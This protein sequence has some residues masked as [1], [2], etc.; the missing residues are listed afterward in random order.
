MSKVSVIVP[1]YGVEPYLR[2]CLDSLVNQTLKDI[3]IIMCID[4]VSPDNCELICNEYADKYENFSLIKPPKSGLSGTRNAG[5]EVAK[6]DFI[7]YVDS[8]DWVETDTLE[9]MYDLAIKNDCEVVSV[10]SISAYGDIDKIENDKEKLVVV[11]GKKVFQSW[12]NC[13]FNSVC[14]H[15]YKREVFA[16]LRFPVGKVSEDTKYNFE[17]FK[18]AKSVVR[19]NQKKYYYFN[20]PKSISRGVLNPKMLDYTMFNQEI[21]EY[22]KEANKKNVRYARACVAKSCFGVLSRLAIYG[23]VDVNEKELKRDLLKKFRTNYFPL[24]FSKKYGVFKKILGFIMF[25]NYTLFKFLVKI[26]YKEK[27]AKV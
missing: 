1:V 24:L 12:L 16:R 17:V 18:I 6:G 15:L 26:F 5:L 9:Y 19:S 14:T 27:N 2:R 13:D 25:I 8:D 11:K 22:C 3:D 20:A 7:S 23:S 10:K 21:L 4:G